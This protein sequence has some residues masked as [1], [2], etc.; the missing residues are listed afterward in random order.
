MLVLTG[1]EDGTADPVIH[2]LSQRGVPVVRMD[3]GDFPSAMTVEA[4]F[5]GDRWRGSAR[6]A[7]RGVDLESVRGVY[8]RRPS[9]FTLTAGMSAPEQ[10]WAYR[11]ARMG[12]GGVLLSLDCLWINQ[13]SKMSAAEY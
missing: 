1:I 11:E 5:G 2:H 7:F 6:E 4:E 10:R 9:Q 3:P 8:Y 12:L 13:P